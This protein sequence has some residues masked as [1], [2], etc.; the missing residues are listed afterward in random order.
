MPR[1]NSVLQ[2]SHRLR[3]GQGS[4]QPAHFVLA[5]QE[6]I[7]CQSSAPEWRMRGETEAGRWS[8]LLSGAALWVQA[9]RALCSILC[10]LPSA[11]GT[12]GRHAA[13]WV[14]MEMPHCSSSSKEQR[15]YKCL[16]SYLLPSIN[17]EVLQVQ[18]CCCYKAHLKELWNHTATNLSR[19]YMEPLCSH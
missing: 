18:S 2:L 11:P 10:S 12:Q 17:Q 4:L 15:A 9:P 16:L 6:A 14:K 13:H 8:E 5:E 3:L 19:N 7:L 1:F